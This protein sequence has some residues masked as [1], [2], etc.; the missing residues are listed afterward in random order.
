MLVNQFETSWIMKWTWSRLA[1]IKFYPVLPGSL[2]CYK[3]RLH[4]KSFV[5]AKRD[6]SFL[7]PGSP[8]VGT[9]FSHV[10]TS[11]YLSGMKKLI[12]TSV[13][14]KYLY[15]FYDAYDASLWEKS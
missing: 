7:L 10:I 8:F 12:N 13:D 11:N 6:P 14:L 5:P 3:L 4:L 15:S 1:G 2:Q 9:K